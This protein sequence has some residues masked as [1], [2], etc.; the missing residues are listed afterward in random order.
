[1]NPLVIVGDQPER[2]RRS[3]DIELLPSDGRMLPVDRTAVHRTTAADVLVTGVRPVSAS[4]WDVAIAIPRSHWLCHPTPDRIPLTLLAETFRQAGLAI[5]IVSVGVEKDVHFVI[6]E[7]TVTLTDQPLAFPRFGSLDTT[8]L[9]EFTET[10]VRKGVLHKL[11]VDFE[12]PGHA[13]GH[14]SA[15]VLR[16]RDYRAIRRSAVS[17]DSTLAQTETTLLKEVRMT[18]AGLQAVLGINEADPFFF[19]HSVDHLPGMLL[20]EAATAAHERVTGTRSDSIDIAFSGFA[21]LRTP[22][23]VASLVTARGTATSFLQRGQV[24]A[25]ATVTSPSRAEVA[26]R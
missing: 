16:D 19:D 17:L 5:C 26:G 14:V 10:T 18:E 3:D 7:M 15:Q 25:S 11:E 20:F 4:S 2:P 22:T 9:V 13:R 12:L 23:T 8:L 21:E 6:S 1:M 24:V